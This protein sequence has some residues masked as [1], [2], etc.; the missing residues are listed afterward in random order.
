MTRKPI[1]TESMARCRVMS[2]SMAFLTVCFIG[3]S[4]VHDT[5]RI[6]LT[7]VEASRTLLQQQQQKQTFLPSYDQNDISETLKSMGGETTALPKLFVFD[8]HY[9]KLYAV[10]HRDDEREQQQQ[11]PTKAAIPLIVKALK[12]NHG[13]R[14]KRGS[15]PFQVLL[16]DSGTTGEGQAAPVL[17]FAA[18]S[19][20]NTTASSIHHRFP[21]PKYLQCLYNYTILQHQGPCH[22]PG[23]AIDTDQ[24]W[25]DL[26]PSIFWRGTNDNSETVTSSKRMFGSSINQ[27]SS[28]IQ[29]AVVAITTDNNEIEQQ[30]INLEGAPSSSRDAVQPTH[31]ALMLR[32]ETLTPRW[33]SVALSRKAK[34]EHHLVQSQEPL[35]VNA[36]FTDTT[37]IVGVEQQHEYKYHL[38][39]GDDDDLFVKLQ[40]PGAL[41]RQDDAQQWWW[42]SED[43]NLKPW[44]H[45]IPIDWGHIGQQYIWAQHNPDRVAIISQNAHQLV[46][47][48]LSGAY[49]TKV[50]QEKF[51]DYLGQVLGAYRADGTDNWETME[52]RYQEAGFRLQVVTECDYR[53]CVSKS[54]G[55]VVTTEVY[56]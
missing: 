26:I 3:S 19:S 51:V 20:S 46:Q 52:K 37:S 41:F 32:W 1:I 22:W 30:Q 55:D 15:P 28:P 36:E 4:M 18:S 12:E 8:G 13:I 45:Y 5:E 38:E 54:N 40:M 6:A 47:N 17:V 14:F 21:D 33:K 42:S 35:W 53:Q 39:F 24:D 31:Q 56:V 2:F 16:D 11:Q 7:A 44:I 25:H 27:E 9:F 23:A 10:E 34:Y 49:M 50:Y 29:Q 48:I 43:Y